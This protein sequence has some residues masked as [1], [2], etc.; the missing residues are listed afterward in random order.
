MLGDMMNSGD[1][2]KDEFGGGQGGGA[3]SGGSFETNNDTPP[4]PSNSN[5][6]PGSTFS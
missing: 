2:Q 5:I 3:G 4:Q 1:S 6:Y